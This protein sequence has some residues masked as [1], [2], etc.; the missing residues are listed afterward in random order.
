[1]HHATQQT[2][3]TNLDRAKALLIEWKAWQ[4]SQGLS[5]RT[6]Y[7][8]ELAVRSLLAFTGEEAL[9]LT[10]A[11]IV[12]FVGRKRLAASTRSSYHAHIRAFCKWL[13]TTDRRADNPCEKT[14]SPKRRKHLPRP[15]LDNQFVAV[16]K[17]CED[18]AD[19][20]LMVML[21]ACAGLREFEI[22]KLHDD[23]LQLERGVLTVT[24]KGGKTAMVPLQDDLWAELR[25]H[26]Y[27]KRGY[28]FPS[29][30]WT[31]REHITRS[32]VYT[33]IKRV[34][35]SAGVEGTPHQ[36]RH[37]YGT[38][39]LE[40]GNDIRIV[41]ELMRHESTATTQIYT[42]VNMTMRRSGIALLRMPEGATA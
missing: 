34:M 23:D 14:P 32:W 36:L 20:R 18:D 6:T 11:G 40:A 31:D 37:W 2:D 19:V 26:R 5:E 30:D 4:T 3:M 25:R 21:Y 1:M 42:R 9:E 16:L 7:E 35:R 22:A 10:S 33:K 27:G 12:Q 15:L 38:S 29:P 28:V 8:R 41:Q 13:V 24:G 39:L 17:A